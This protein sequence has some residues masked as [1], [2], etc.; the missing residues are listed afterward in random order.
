MRYEGRL[1]RPP[2]EADSYI[3]QVTVGCAHNKCTFCSMYKEK[4]FH[5]RSIE[6]ILEDLALAQK[7]YKKV[8]RIFLADGDA[9][10]LRMDTLRI[11]LKEIKR[12]FPDTEGVGIYARA[13]DITRKS[14]EELIELNRL[15][16]DII[17]MGF[18]SGDENILS[19]IQKGESTA[20]MIEAA[21]LIKK[22]SIY[23]LVTMLNGIGG[24]EHWKEHAL[25]SAKILN[26]MQP[27]FI[28]L[29]ALLKDPAAPIYSQIQSGAIKMLTPTQVLQETKM[30]LEHLKVEDCVFSTHHAIN[31]LSIEGV[32]P[33]DK[34]KLM[35]VLEDG[36]NH[37]QTL[38]N[39][40]YRRL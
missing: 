9:L 2:S 25:N 7:T 5:I 20:D 13:K 19:A 6:A 37:P 17:Y 29:S 24:Q 39:D 11:I 3:L 22:T 14:Q 12:L 18:E 26:Q 32:L 33:R 35:N 27:D 4:K 8:H 40:A 36:I 38:K 34:S 16:I 28:G 31:Y 1:F 30:I 23:L 21:Q 15:G 10:V